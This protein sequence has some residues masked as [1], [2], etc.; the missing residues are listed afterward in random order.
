MPDD[1][2]SARHVM[3][4]YEKQGLPGCVSSVH[5]IHVC[6]DRCPSSMHSTSKGK[7]KVPTLVFK[8]AC[9]H[10]RKILH[11][12]QS[13]GGTYNDKTISRINPLFRLLCDDDA[14]L[15]N[16]RWT[17]VA[18]DG[19]HQNHCGAYLICDGGYNEW[20]CLMPP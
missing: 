8:V 3:G 20:A 19:T 1:E 10:T 5:C 18:R 6:W 15:R 9:S 12:P 7:D 2:N 13:F 4:L 11:V 16:L 14:F 17:S